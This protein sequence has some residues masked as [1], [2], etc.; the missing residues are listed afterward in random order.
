MDTN[1]I[2]KM[3]ESEQLEHDQRETKNIF[4]YCKSKYQGAT[5]PSA[6][7]QVGVLE[8][9]QIEFLDDRNNG[10]SFVCIEGGNER[11]QHPFVLLATRYRNGRYVIHDRRGHQTFIES[12]DQ[13]KDAFD[14]IVAQ[15]D[16]EDISRLTKKL[17]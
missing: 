9:W 1:L 10:V 8:A 16:S 4:D 17:P 6:G 15:I 2:A 11:G 5:L 13:W 3:S 12:F 14:K 7:V